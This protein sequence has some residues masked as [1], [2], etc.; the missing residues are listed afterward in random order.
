M[1]SKVRV[2]VRGL[3]FLWLKMLYVEVN[4][5]HQVDVI[6]FFVCVFIYIF[7]LKAFFYTVTLKEPDLSSKLLHHL[8]FNF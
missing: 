7:S 6:F 4:T 3:I 8:E 1:R 2:W 5:L